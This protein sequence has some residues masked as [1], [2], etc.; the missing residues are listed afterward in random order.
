MKRIL[1]AGIGNIFYGDDAFGCETVKKLIESEL[2]P[3]VKAVDFGT[4]MRDLAFELSENYDIVVFFDAAKRGGKPGD[5]YLIELEAS[6]RNQDN[7]FFSHGGRLEDALAFARE[8]GAAIGKAYL[9]GLEPGSFDE[10]SPNMDEAVGKAI[11]IAEKL[12]K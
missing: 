3:W 6:L 10:K 5:I 2:L 1:I 8:L 7:T 4:R 11:M 12:I 9:I